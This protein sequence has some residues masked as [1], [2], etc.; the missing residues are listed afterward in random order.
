VD[1]TVLVVGGAGYIGSHMVKMLGRSGARVVVLDN[2]SRGHADA[3]GSA[4]LHRGD[5]LVPESIAAVFR[6]H[7]IDLVM[8]FAALCY[9][10]ESV[11]FPAMYYRNN[12]AGSLNLIDAMLDAGV[13][14]LVFSSTCATYGLPQAELMSESH[15]QAPVNPYGRSKL[16]VEEAL[17]D[18]GAAYGLESIALRYF[19]AAGADPEG[20]LGERHDPETHLI[21]LVLREARRVLSGGDPADTGLSVYGD[22]F[23]TPDGTCIR[24]Y[25]HVTDLC[26]A[27]LLAG[28]RL[29]D[30][31]SRGFEACNLGTG[32]G[33]SVKEVIA[34]AR[35]ATGADIRYRVAGRRAGDPHR[36]VASAARARSV[37]GWTPR[38]SELRTIIDTAWRYLSARRSGGLGTR[39]SGLR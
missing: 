15:P 19:N 23:D 37:L 21:P 12:F 36:L 34:A 7:P 17:A 14:R 4:R 29:L 13:H 39:D 38:H 8:H 1:A 33:Y 5:L 22:D 11:E 16:A 32:R 26:E 2:L 28:R 31:E 25:V 24:D 18:Y 35:E 30:G 6:Q 3:I 20:E 10:G 9:V 27:H